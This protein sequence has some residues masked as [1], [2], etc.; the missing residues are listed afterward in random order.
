VI[1]RGA[2]RVVVVGEGALAGEVVRNLSLAGIPASMHRPADFWATLR[3]ADLQDCYCAVA[4][5]C[6]W[7][8][9][10][11]LNALVQVAGVDFVSVSLGPEGIVL[12]TFPYGSDA[13]C[14]C[15][16]CD[17]GAEAADVVAVQPDPIATGIAG[18]LAAA[19]AL[20]CAGTGARRLSIPALV[21]A[22]TSTPLQRRDG[23]PACAPPLRA[24]R[25]V[26]TRNR[27][28]PRAAIC[29]DTAALDGQTLR[30]SDPIVIRCECPHCGPVAALDGAVNR[31]LRELPDETPACPG[32]GA[33]AL[34][35][36]VR[37]EF[38]LRELAER[39][40]G[41]PVPAKFALA[42]IG[43]IAVCFDLE[44]APARETGAA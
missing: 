39:F 5:G 17:F 1:E 29:P 43:G 33:T 19:A 37:D 28:A 12:G 23:C 25:V 27:W 15:V 16:E 40:G 8:A 21:A 2:A 26:R 38:S 6:D 24:P 34:R 14:A 30:L 41:G 35:V 9:L 13:G 18:G 42:S 4:A 32:C 7:Q 31:P 10:R 22:S 44:S 36:E 20:Q 11:R 3:L